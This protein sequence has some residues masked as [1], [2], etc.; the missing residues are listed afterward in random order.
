MPPQLSRIPQQSSRNTQQLLRNT[1]AINS[2]SISNDSETQEFLQIIC[3]FLIELIRRTF[4]FRMF[5]FWLFYV[6]HTLYFNFIGRYS[7]W[8]LGRW[9]E[10]S[11]RRHGRNLGILGK[12]GFWWDVFVIVIILGEDVDYRN[13]MRLRLVYDSAVIFWGC[14]EMRTNLISCD[15]RRRHEDCLL[16]SILLIRSIYLELSVMGYPSHTKTSRWRTYKYFLSLL[17]RTELWMHKWYPITLNRILNYLMLRK[18]L[19]LCMRLLL[20]DPIVS[21]GWHCV[22]IICFIRGESLRRMM[23]LTLHIARILEFM[24]ILVLS[25]VL[26]VTLIR[27]SAVI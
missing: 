2:L 27:I 26:T 16:L 21:I 8:L 19:R 6:R 15:M 7:R 25:H 1:P 22:V 14:R 17:V 23:V 18:D 9:P 3:N 24:E 20:V 4:S 11:Q 13:I 12:I 10:T 5:S